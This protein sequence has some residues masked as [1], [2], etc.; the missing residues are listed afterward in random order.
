MRLMS[1]RSCCLF[2]VCLGLLTCSVASAQEKPARLT[3]EIGSVRASDPSLEEGTVQPFPS[4]IGYHA[5]QMTI[6]NML[7]VMYRI[8]GR[9]I[10][11]GPEWVYTEKFDV[12]GKAD[13]TY[14]IDEL[15]VMFE[16][17]LMDRFNLK[18]HFVNETGPVYMLRVAKSGLKMKQVPVGNDR[19]S[20]IQGNDDVDVTGDRVP[21][22]YLCYWLGQMLQADHRPVVDRTGLTGTYSFRL[23]FHPELE[24]SVAAADAGESED[25]PSIFHALPDQLGLELTP[26]RGPIQ[27]L[28]IDHI[29]KPSSN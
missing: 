19:H 8:T 15:H 7:A 12:V 11:G 22:N 17:L 1:L 4:G 6:K 3:Y 10:T 27:T 14:S 25:L 13:R 24:P 29:E 21:M 2:L 5:D 26:E 23:R 9:Q 18:L 16:N 20:P 28:V